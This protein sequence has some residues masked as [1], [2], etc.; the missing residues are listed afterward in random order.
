MYDYLA[1]V[2]RWIDGDTIQLDVDLGFNIHIVE[3]FRVAR[4]NAPEMNTFEGKAAKDYAI[5]LIPIGAMVKIH[6]SKRDT[7]IKE[8]KYGRW[9]AEIELPTGENFSDLMLNSGHAILWK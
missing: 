3:K 7:A 4:I 2:D 1:K 6:S 5:S 9:L 8:E